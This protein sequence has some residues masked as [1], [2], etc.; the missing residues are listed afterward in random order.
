MSIA[1]AIQNAQQKVANAYTAVSTKGGTL[2]ATQDL[3]NLPTAINSIPTG[4]SGGP[5]DYIP[6]EVSQSGLLKRPATGFIFK[7]TTTATDI[8]QYLFDGL[9]DASSAATQA[10][11]TQVDLS[12]I[13]TLTNQYSLRKTFYQC[14]N[15][16]SI[17]LGSL[18]T[19][20]GTEAMK[21][22][23]YGCTSLTDI[24]L[25]SLTTISGTEGARGAFQ[26]CTKLVSINLSSLTTIS[27][28]NGIGET[29]R[30]CT[31]LANVDL[32]SLSSCTATR[33]GMSRTFQGCTSLTSLDLSSLSEVTGPNDMENLC[34][35]CTNLV[36]IDLSGLT[37]VSGANV[38]NYLCDGCTSLTSVDFSSLASIQASNALYYAFRNCTSLTTLSFPSLTST[39]FGS[40]TTQFNRMLYGVTGCT[41]HFPSNLQSVIGS[42][43][44]VTAGFGGTNTT[45]LFDL[46]ATT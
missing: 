5:A 10:N 28:V 8:A 17:D 42:W 25:S 15:L 6:L 24:D 4:G 2:P 38:M 20:S 1:T 26:G 36:S 3:S 7:P 21:T 44:D 33:Y 43:A 30:G 13:Q 12:S 32:S 34:T 39:S 14:T 45:V 22:M 18:V 16:T 35:G 46:P 37:T 41:V 31:K 27:G 9:Y 23:C 40:N 11:V 19:V 29:F